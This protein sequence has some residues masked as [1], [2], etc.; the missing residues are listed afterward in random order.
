MDLFHH[1]CVMFAF[2]VSFISYNMVSVVALNGR[3]VGLAVEMLHCYECSS[4]FITVSTLCVA[5]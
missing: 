4:S 5:V 1:S 2:L 3:G